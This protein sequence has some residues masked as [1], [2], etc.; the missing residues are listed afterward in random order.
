MIR[1]REAPE[2]IAGYCRRASRQCIVEDWLARTSRIRYD[3]PAEIY[4]DLASAFAGQAHAR[5]WAGAKAWPREGDESSANQTNARR[6]TDQ[7]NWCGYHS[8]DSAHV[9]KLQRRRRPLR[10]RHPPDFHD[11]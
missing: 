3:S 5:R 9:C 7:A 11:C 2:S 1:S 4:A 6:T 8:G 10:R